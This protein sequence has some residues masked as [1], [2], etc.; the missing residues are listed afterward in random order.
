MNPAQSAPQGQ[1]IP[2]VVHPFFA[3]LTSFFS[4]PGLL[5]FLPLPLS[6]FLSLPR[7]CSVIFNLIRLAERGSSLH[8]NT[9]FRA[10]SSPFLRDTYVLLVLLLPPKH[11]PLLIDRLSK[12]QQPAYS[13]QCSRL[14]VVL[15]P[16]TY[17]FF[18]TH[19]HA[20]ASSKHHGGR[21]ENRQLYD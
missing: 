7:L 9:R 2:S 4:S 11:R 14:W 3:L 12:R 15:I 13:S 8:S 1:S 20:R 17:L 19:R 10:S 21:Q 16:P 5:L 18:H 6:L